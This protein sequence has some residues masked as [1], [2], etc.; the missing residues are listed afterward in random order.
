MYDSQMH[1]DEPP[2]DPEARPTVAGPDD[3]QARAA[4]GEQP[5]KPEAVGCVF[6]GF[7]VQV[8]ERSGDDYADYLD[9]L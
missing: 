2:P 4:G 7:G 5:R 8:V 1:I 6:A 3:P 9:E